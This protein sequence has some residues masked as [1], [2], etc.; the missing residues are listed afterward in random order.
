MDL[1]R[2]M[3]LGVYHPDIVTI[4]KNIQLCWWANM[5]WLDAWV[6]CI[7]SL[8]PWR[9]SGL[10]CPMWPYS[11]CEPG[12]VPRG[13]GNCGT[14]CPGRGKKNTASTRKSH[15]STDSN[16]SHFLSSSWRLVTSVS[17]HGFRLMSRLRIRVCLPNVSAEV[18]TVLNALGCVL[19]S[20]SCFRSYAA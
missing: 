5:K 8:G 14:Y 15:A 16:P 18:W 6:H 17:S 2:S 11:I 12:D 4:H 3:D 9:R 7:R 10:P 19:I 13:S 20:R 1:R